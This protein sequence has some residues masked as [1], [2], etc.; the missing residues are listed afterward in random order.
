MASVD[1]QEARKEIIKLFNA[2]DNNGRKVI[3]WYDPPMNFKED[4]LSDSFDC[5]RVLMY[6]KNEFTIKKT[7]EHDE[8]DT[9]FL[10]YIPADKPIDNE[11]WLLDILMY[12]EEYY[13]DTVA[14]TMRRLGLTNTD[15][16]RII[17]RYAK[18]F[19]SETRNKKLN[20][21]VEVCDQMSGEDLKM[22]MMCVLVK[23]TSRSIESVLIELVFDISFGTKYAELMKFGFEEYLWDEIAHYYNYEGDQRMEALVRK[24]LFTALLEQKVDFGAL[25]S[26]YSQYTIAGAGKMDAKFFVD[27]IKS[28]KCYQALQFDIAGDLKIEG[29]LVS[30]DIFCVQEAD[31]FECIDSH[32][33]K[34]IA[35]GLQNGSLDYDTFERVIVSRM[36]SI[37]HDEHKAE[38]ELLASTIAFAIF[39]EYFSSPKP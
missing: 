14:L 38:Y 15:L 5:C 37:W 19:D 35:Q 21:Y 9:D 10:V 25:P 31:V 12:S 8:A 26:F 23:A 17:E 24:F 20:T 32:I 33:I 27:K 39:L 16:R 4:I 29:L 18:F 36:N 6:E 22:A 1:Y 3:F 13:A 28:D 7:I 30:R 34:T 2:K 11:N